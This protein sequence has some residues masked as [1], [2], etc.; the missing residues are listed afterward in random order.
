[1]I[2]DFGKG[3]EVALFSLLLHLSFVSRHK[4]S[5]WKCPQF[6]VLRL[7]VNLFLAPFHGKKTKKNLGC[8]PQ[9]GLEGASLPPAFGAAF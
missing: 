1:M 9:A 3:L 4:F 7:A 8:F 5:R 2:Q 6:K